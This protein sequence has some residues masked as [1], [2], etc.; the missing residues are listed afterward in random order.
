MAFLP[1]QIPDRDFSYQVAVQR[2]SD[3]SIG[4]AHLGG[5][6]RSGQGIVPILVSSSLT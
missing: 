3:G 5:G 1:P 6:A 4:L 2:I